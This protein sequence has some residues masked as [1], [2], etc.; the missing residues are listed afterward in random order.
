LDSEYYLIYN[1]DP[2]LTLVL[3]NEVN[4][5]IFTHGKVV[6]E[7]GAILNGFIIAS[8]RGYTDSATT[9]YVED[10][11][12]GYVDG[13]AAQSNDY[14]PRIKENGSNL[15][16]LDN[17]VSAGVEFNVI[18]EKQR[19]IMGSRNAFHSWWIVY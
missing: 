16:N 12:A 13:Y 5:I 18:L 14:I 8:G 2:K 17:G 19:L 9:G 6:L 10:Y 3:N 4:G 1:D 7:P 11:T 15:L